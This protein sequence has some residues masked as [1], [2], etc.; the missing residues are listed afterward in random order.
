VTPEGNVILRLVSPPPTAAPGEPEP[1]APAEPGPAAPDAA[2][3]APPGPAARAPA[4]SAPTRYGEL[5]L[6]LSL[7]P[8]LLQVLLSG[9][10]VERTTPAGAWQSWRQ[11]PDGTL[12]SVS[13]TAQ[14]LP[15]TEFGRWRVDE[16]GRYCFSMAWQFGEPEAWC[17]H[18]VKSDEGYFLVAGPQPEDPARRIY[19][20]GR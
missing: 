3:P 7:S 6:P 15:L 9:A 4:A 16:E 8:A 20:D 5:T 2:E 12:S 1:A 10:T 11:R 19:I 18:V 17:H 13:T 14:G